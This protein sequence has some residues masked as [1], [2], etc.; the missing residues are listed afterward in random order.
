MKASLFVILLISIR[1][2]GLTQNSPFRTK[3]YFGIQ[4]KPLIA[5]NFLGSSH[6][7]LKNDTLKGSFTQQ[8]GSS[9]GGVIR[10]NFKKNISLETGINYV[11]RNYNV[12]FSRLDSAITTS[13]SLKI[14]SFEIP[15]NVLFYVKLTDKIYMNNSLGTAFIFNPSNVAIDAIYDQ[16]NAFRAEGRIRSVYS[17]EM[18]ANFGFEYRTVSDGF[19]YIGASGRVPFKPIFDVDVSNQNTILH[20]TMVLYGSMSGTYVS[21]DFRYFFPYNNKANNRSGMPIEQ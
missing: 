12:E 7:V 17:V 8:L 9:F 11:Q 4:F 13:K 6:L 3:A 20:Q 10:I 21:F 16:Y 14:T 1:I 19:F 15:L 18:N 5:G 2:V